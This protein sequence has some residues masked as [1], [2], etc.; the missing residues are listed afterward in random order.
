M[1]NTPRARS[2][3]WFGANDAGAGSRSRLVGATMFGVTTPCVNARA[4]ERPRGSWGYEV[5]V[6]HA[7]GCRAG[8][9]SEAA[10]AANG[11]PR[12]VCSTATTT[13]ASA[14][15]SSVGGVSSI[16]AGPEPARGCRRSGACRRS[17]RSAP[18]RHG[19]L[20]VRARRVPPQVPRGR[21]LYVHKPDRDADAHERPERMRRASAGTNRPQ[22]LLPAQGPTVL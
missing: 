5:L 12:P 18:P 19:E 7:T 10:R 3:E 8:S 4:R 21:N 16:R 15:R 20:S 1:A 11:F 22:A 17:S 6:F 14:G 13:R 9:R 2:P